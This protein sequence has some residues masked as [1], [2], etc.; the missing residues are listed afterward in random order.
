M[1]GSIATGSNVS[2]E[3]VEK[4]SISM[5]PSLI[6]VIDA[7]EPNRSA[8]FGRLAEEDLRERALLPGSDEA[9]ALRE[10]RDMMRLHGPGAFRDLLRRLATV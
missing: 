9:E 8:Y 3:K 1:V 5:A 6:A 7:N 10:A 4:I 2:D